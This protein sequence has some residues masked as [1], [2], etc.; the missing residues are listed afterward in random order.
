MQKEYWNNVADNVEFNLPLNA[1]KFL[2]IIDK[3]FSILDVGCGYGRTMADLFAIGYKRIIGIDASENMVLRG[4]NAHPYLDIRHQKGKIFSLKENSF[5][6]IILFEV[7]SGIHKK[8]EQQAL[9]NEIKRVLKP[10][11]L[12]F[13]NDYL[14]SKDLKNS[15]QYMK[16]EDKY[17]DFGVFETADGYITKHYYEK[18]I[19]ELFSDF[20]IVAANKNKLKNTAGNF[21]STMD[22]IFKLR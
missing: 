20:D 13:F 2:E 15:L 8:D 5:D 11:G 12:V 16:F 1:N 6:V 7:L 9:L 17:S 4:K 3:N 14:I 21:V 22:A 18:D 19:I 10:N